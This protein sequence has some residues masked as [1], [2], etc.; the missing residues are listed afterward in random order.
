MKLLRKSRKGTMMKNNEK[1]G[2][3]V[4]IVSGLV[5]MIIAITLLVNIA[6]SKEISD[7][8][9]E[10]LDQLSQRIEQI[11]E[12]DNDD[13]DAVRLKIGNIQNIENFNVQNMIVDD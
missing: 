12:D 8:T 9:N 10:S 1:T 13:G 5:L 6:A 11:E 4:A 3:V 7:T 2:I